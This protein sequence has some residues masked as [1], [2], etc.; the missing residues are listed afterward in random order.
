MGGGPEPQGGQGDAG[1]RWWG[2][3]IQTPVGS[4]TFGTVLQLYLALWIARTIFFSTVSPPLAPTLPAGAR[5]PQEKMARAGR[6]QELEGA[7]IL[8]EAIVQAAPT[9]GRDA[10]EAFVRPRTLITIGLFYIVGQYL[11][12]G[13]P[14]AGGQRALKL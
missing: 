6:E 12:S 13:R 4:I 7:S 3:A 9:V 10:A 5:Q 2:A 1:S 8:A 14:Q 11:R